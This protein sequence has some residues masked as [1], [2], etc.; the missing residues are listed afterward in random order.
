MEHHPNFVEQLAEIE[1]RKIDD[2][3]AEIDQLH[4]EALAE[5]V[6]REVMALVTSYG[7]EIEHDYWGTERTMLRHMTPR[8]YDY[9]I[10][11]GESE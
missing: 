1:Q 5:H 6:R 2:A 8:G 7:F 11:L 4:L 3:R 10:P 9:E